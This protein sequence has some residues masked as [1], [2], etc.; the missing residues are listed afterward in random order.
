M[1]TQSKSWNHAISLEDTFPFLAIAKIFSVEITSSTAIV[2]C[3]RAH[4]HTHTHTIYTVNNFQGTGVAGSMAAS[5]FLSEGTA[6]SIYRNIN[7]HW[8]Q[9]PS[10]CCHC[11]D[12]LGQTSCKLICPR[13]AIHDTHHVVRLD[14]QSFSC[15]LV[16]GNL[17]IS[18]YSAMHTI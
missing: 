14:F 3:A 13:N 1:T 9:L 6:G 2:V 4:T 17:C 15:R 7:H 11:Q 8:S 16:R 5:L 18:T 10:I 12:L